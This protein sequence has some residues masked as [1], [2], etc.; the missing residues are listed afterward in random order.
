MYLAAGLEQ[1]ARIG[2]EE[3]EKRDLTPRWAPLRVVLGDVLGGAFQR[4]GRRQAALGRGRPRVRC[5]NRAGPLGT[6]RIGVLVLSAQYRW[7]SARKLSPSGTGS[8]YRRHT[9]CTLAIMAFQ[10]SRSTGLTT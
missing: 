7:S 3:G 9:E 4:S 2:P 6:G 10:S 1:R 8:A 5:G